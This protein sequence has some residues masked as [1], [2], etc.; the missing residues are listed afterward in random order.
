[1]TE[2]VEGEVEVE[3]V[4]AG[5]AEEAELA[6]G[7]VVVDEVDEGGFGEVAG[8][9]DAGDLVVGRGGRDVGIEAGAGGGDEVDGDGRGA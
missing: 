9:G 1:V 2:G 7:G 4:D 6:L 3:G 5:F 8:V